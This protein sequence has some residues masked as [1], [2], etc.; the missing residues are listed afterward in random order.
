MDTAMNCSCNTL[1][2]LLVLLL[3][4]DHNT[5]ETTTRLHIYCHLQAETV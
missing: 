1:L 5:T 4:Q 2:L 3:L